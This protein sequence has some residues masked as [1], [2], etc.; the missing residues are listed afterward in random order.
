MASAPVTEDMEDTQGN[1]YF[2]FPSLS[3]SSII[4]RPSCIH[5][6]H[7]L[8]NQIKYLEV[9]TIATYQQELASNNESS[10]SIA[11]PAD[12]ERRLSNSSTVTK[13][14]AYI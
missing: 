13:P 4:A 3:P 1:Q 2:R 10:A 14:L 12:Q 11:R 7:S 5:K 9:E 8:I 6:H